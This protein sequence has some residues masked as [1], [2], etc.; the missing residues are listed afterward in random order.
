MIDLSIKKRYGQFQINVEFAFQRKGVTALIGESGAGKTSIINMVAGLTRPDHG[1]ITINN[2]TL[3]DSATGSNILPEKRHIGYIFQDGRLFPHLSVQHNLVYGMNLVPKQDRFIKVDQV[4]DLLGIGHLLKRMP[5][6]LSG[7]EKQRVAIGR[8]ILTSPE[9]LL[10]D[11]PL[12]SLDEAR[13]SDVLPFI[14]KLTREFSI[15]I[16]YVSHSLNEVLNLADTIVILS[17]GRVVSYGETDEVLSRPDMQQFLGT[18]NYGALISTVI[19][20][21]SQSLTH[22]RFHGGLLHVPLLRFKKG[23]KII[24]LIKARNVAISLEMPS[25][26]SF[27]NILPARVDEIIE[28]DEMM[29]DIHLDIGCMIISRITCASKESLGLKPGQQVY[30]LVKGVAVST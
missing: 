21:H 14:A 22:L 11:E 12:A 30:A 23:S 2:R 24:V 6:N 15:P 28:R 7:G 8:A 13:K 17:A 16:L 1:H 10:M 20:D 9:F 4:V 27:Q 26:T 5:S 29:V 18:S 25:N 19:E 3:F